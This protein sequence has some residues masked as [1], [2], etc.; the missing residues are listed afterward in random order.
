VKKFLQIDVSPGEY[1][2]FARSIGKDARYLDCILFK[3][4]QAKNISA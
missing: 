3:Y 4:G 1:D 2:D